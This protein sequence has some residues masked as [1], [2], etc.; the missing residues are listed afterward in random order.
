MGWGA[1][2]K[3]VTDAL[4]SV[5]LIVVLSPLLLLI[6]VLVKLTSPGPIL[7]SQERMGLDGRSFAMLKFRSMKADAE[8][9]SGAVWADV[10]DDRRTKLGTFLRK[11]S[12]DELPQLWNVLY[13]DMSLVGPRPERPIFVNKFRKEIPHYMLRHKVRAGITGWAQ[14]NGW[15]G[16]TSLE[17]RIEC[18]LFYIKNWSYILDLK[19][20]TMTVWKGFINKN[21]Y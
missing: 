16:N 20:L 5:I 11:T 19:I 15:R 18:D 4:V 2:A 17:S 14:V 6:A 3:R 13:G 21:A 9:H 1:I 12:L 8:R 10:K 7:Y